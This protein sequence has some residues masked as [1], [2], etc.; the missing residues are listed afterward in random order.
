MGNDTLLIK[1]LAEGNRLIFKRIFEDYYR[2]LCGFSRKFIADT[3]V[4]DDIVQESFL[5]LWN[6][7]AEISSFNAIKSYLYSSVRNACL[8]HLRH[9]SVK[10]KSEA[11]ILALSSDWYL[12][13]SI[14]EE[15]VHSQI[16]EAIED[17]SP[18]SRKVVIMTMNGLTNP[19]IAADLGVSVN[20]VKTLKQRGYQ[21]LRGR[22]KGMHWLLLLLLA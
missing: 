18:Q 7:R 1:Q 10:E 4:C 12:E 16:Y 2:P 8:N 13:D 15:E 14:V 3:D 22:L 6:R 20:T 5:G 21:F 17:L 9:Q 19:E 11:D